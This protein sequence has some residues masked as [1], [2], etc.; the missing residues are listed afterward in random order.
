MDDEVYYYHQYTSRLPYFAAT[1][2]SLD[3]DRSGFFPLALWNV[4]F[5]IFIFS[6]LRASKV[7]QLQRA[8]RWSLVPQKMT[9]ILG[10][11]HERSRTNRTR[12]QHFQ[13]DF[14]SLPHTAIDAVEV[15]R[16]ADRTLFKQMSLD[17]SMGMIRSTTHHKLLRMLSS[18]G[19]RWPL[20]IQVGYASA[21]VPL[22]NL[23]NYL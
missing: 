3:K 18:N 19:Q 7:Q 16:A 8:K 13:H 12:A 20:G 4:T 17:M 5:D 10:K 14:G 22:L 15:A 1:P 23:N 9:H 21:T 11:T 6:E 2:Q